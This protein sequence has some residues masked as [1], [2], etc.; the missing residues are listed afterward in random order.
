M[1]RDGSAMKRRCAE[2]TGKGGRG[3]ECAE[4]H[5]RLRECNGSAGQLPEVVGRLRQ[6]IGV[7]G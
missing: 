3:T 7:Q 5:G 4:G 1:A 2:C 6:G